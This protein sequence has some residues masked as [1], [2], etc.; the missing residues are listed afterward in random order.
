MKIAVPITDAAEF[1]SHYGASSALACFDVNDAT[2][3]LRIASVLKP[4]HRTPCTWPERLRAEGVDVMLVGGMGGGARARCES[5][6][7]RVIAG[8][9]SLPPAELVNAFVSGT[10][11]S[12]EN[13][14]RHGGDDHHHDHAHDGPC[15]CGH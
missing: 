8:V 10:L 1:S 15:H 6:G 14:C 2:R 5:L 13:A 11:H 7:I 3:V 12:G 4:A 9:P